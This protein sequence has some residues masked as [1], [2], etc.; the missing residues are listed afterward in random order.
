MKGLLWRMAGTAAFAWRLLGCKVAGR[1]SPKYVFPVLGI[2]DGEPTIL[3]RVCMVC[4][5]HHPPTDD[6]AAIEAAIRE[7]AAPQRG[8]VPSATRYDGD[9]TLN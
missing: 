1:C 7:A 5:R 3:H 2:E 6:D 9:A 4:G 8:G